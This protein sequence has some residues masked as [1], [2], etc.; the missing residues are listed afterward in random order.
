M[1]RKIRFLAASVAARFMILS[2][3][4]RDIRKKALRGD[5]ILSI[6]F[7]SP[8]KKIF[9]YCIEWLKRNGFEFLSQDDILSI[10][11]GRKP[12]PMGGVIVTVDDGWRS[13]EENIVSVANELQIPITIFVS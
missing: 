5:F 11:D 4:T 6:Y 8:E 7:H 9:K 1:K 13:N 3:F 10:I 12:F 2:G